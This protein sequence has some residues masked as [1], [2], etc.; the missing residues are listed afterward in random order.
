MLGNSITHGA[1]W[2]ELLG[3]SNVVERGISSDVL[4]GYW[5]E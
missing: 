2:N 4:R 1:A 3:R 5:Q